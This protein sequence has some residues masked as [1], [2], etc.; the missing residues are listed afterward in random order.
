MFCLG[1]VVVCRCLSS[2][3][4]FLLGSSWS[5]IDVT[6][7]LLACRYMIAFSHC[8]CSLYSGEILCLVC[9]GCATS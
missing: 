8:L 9:G 1:V 5:C 6:C 4:V 7:D 2:T 3:H